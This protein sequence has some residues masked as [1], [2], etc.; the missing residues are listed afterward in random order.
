MTLLKT[1]SKWQFWESCTSWRG[2]AGK[3]PEA[4][5]VHICITSRPW[6]EYWMCTVGQY[7]PKVHHDPVLIP[8]ILSSLA[9]KPC[10]NSLR[11]T[12]F[13][14]HSVPSW[15]TLTDL[16]LW[17]WDSEQ[18]WLTQS[19]GGRPLTVS[20]CKWCSTGLMYKTQWY[21][22]RIWVCWVEGSPQEG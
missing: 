16:L 9:V 4:Y 3:T 18:V 17:Q 12:H 14:I 6:F 13:F 1:T 20:D 22:K 5:E 15:Q 8:R 11:D 21:R 2:R 19:H 10:P 7:R